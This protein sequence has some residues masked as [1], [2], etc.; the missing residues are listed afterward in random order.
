[1]DILILIILAI[2]IVYF[3]L[4]KAN[5]NKP[6]PVKV[7]EEVLLEGEPN[8][9]KVFCETC[10]NKEISKG[11]V[12]PIVGSGCFSVKGYNL[13]GKEVRLIP[14]QITWKSGCSCVSFASPTGLNN[15]ISC[16]LGNLR[17]VSV[18]CLANARMFGFKIDFG[19]RSK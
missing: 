4:K 14:S 18:K 7:D 3:F 17:D 12:V 5:K 11:E 6:V 13:K 1:M 19:K 16:S 8:S 10:G 2:G 15:C 9:L